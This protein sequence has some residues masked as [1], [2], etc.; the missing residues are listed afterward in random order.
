MPSLSLVRRARFPMWDLW[1]PQ[2]SLVLS[3]GC[4]S[5][6]RSENA[7]TQLSAAGFKDLKNVVGGWQAWVSAG[8]PASK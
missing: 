4:L 3:V 1:D 6:K 2:R 5:G 8:L 7:V